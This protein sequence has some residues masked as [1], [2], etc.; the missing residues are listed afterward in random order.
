MEAAALGTLQGEDINLEIYR[1]DGVGDLFIKAI[2]DDLNRTAQFLHLFD[3][4]VAAE[5]IRKR[6]QSISTLRHRLTHIEKMVVAEKCRAVQ[7]MVRETWFIR[8]ESRDIL[9]ILSL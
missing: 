2:T 6:V 5:R 4:R 9:Y 1:Q 3:M 7:Q 8:A